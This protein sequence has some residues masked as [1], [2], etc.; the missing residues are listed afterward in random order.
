MSFPRQSCG[1]ADG[2]VNVA[3]CFIQLMFFVCI[4]VSRLCAR[5]PGHRPAAELRRVEGR[6]V[7]PDGFH[8]RGHGPAG[9]PGA[10]G[11]LQP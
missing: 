8:D 10:Q 1:K 6:L 2:V 4:C 3:V 5:P 9:A 11:D 7:L